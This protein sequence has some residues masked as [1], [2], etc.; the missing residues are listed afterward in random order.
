MATHP[1]NFPRTLSVSAATENV[2]GLLALPHA[3]TVGEGEDLWRAYTTTTAGMVVRANLVPDAHL[4]SLV[5]EKA[6]RTLWSHD[7]DL[8]K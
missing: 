8:W 4:V 7:R 3:R 6:V 1:A 5:R 2:E